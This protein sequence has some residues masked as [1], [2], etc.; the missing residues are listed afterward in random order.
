MI[1]KLI[2]SFALALIPLVFFAQYEFLTRVS[3]HGCA[4]EKID[5]LRGVAFVQ[6]FAIIPRLTRFVTI[7]FLPE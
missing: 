1:R 4:F 2:F 5:S 7:T 6:I 3:P